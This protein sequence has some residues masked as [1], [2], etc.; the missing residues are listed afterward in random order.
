MGEASSTGTDPGEEAF[1]MIDPCRVR[2]TG[3]LAEHA[4][5]YRAELAVM[6]YVPASAACQLQLMAD[7]SSWLAA[8]GLG[9]SELLSVARTDA[10]LQARRA[11]GCKMFVSRLALAPL[12]RYMVGL[13]VVPAASMLG[14]PTDVLVEKYRRCL[15]D[16]RGLSKRT[17]RNYL[18]AARL[19]LAECSQGDGADLEQT[20]EQMT[21]LLVISFVVEQCRR[22]RPG[23]AKVLVA[24]LRSLLRYLFVSG[25]TQQQLAGVVPTPTGFS[26]RSLPRPLDAD[27]V[28]ALLASCDR[29]R[30]LGRR[31]FAILT[32]LARLC[33][34][35]GE[36]AAVLVDDLDWH[37]GEVVVRGKGGRRQLLLLPVD[38]GEALVDYLSDGRPQVECRALFLRI[39]A[40]ITALSP[41]GV[42]GVVRSACS[43]AGIAPVGPHRLRHHGA[44]AMLQSGATLAEVGQA[45]RQSSG[46]ATAVYAKVDRVALRALAQPWP[47]GVR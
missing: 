24:G 35:A 41:E 47:G 15:S 32:V 27:A 46:A 25:Y 33:L 9:A 5:G 44:S 19:F 23:S 43:R 4:D 39:R 20:L 31:D 37:R 2:V 10:F 8:S 12:V 17:V 36:A 45:L 34:R 30:T 40:P 13:G 6:G 26:G 21:A 16:E 1:A 3:P 29:S 18:G 38:V 42:A 7:V 14:S 11:G 28:A 22:Q